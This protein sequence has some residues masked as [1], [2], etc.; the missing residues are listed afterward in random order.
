MIPEVTGFGLTVTAAEPLVV[1][2]QNL[3]FT[4]VTVYVVVAALVPAA[5]IVGAAANVY[6]LEL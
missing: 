4:L 5:G 6:V 3:L 1:P 2:E